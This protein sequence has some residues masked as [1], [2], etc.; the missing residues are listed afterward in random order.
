MNYAVE[1]EAT[2]KTAS[3][4]VACTEESLRY[5]KA[6]KAAL[7]EAAKQTAMAEARAALTLDLLRVPVKKTMPKPNLIE[8]PLQSTQIPPTRGREH[9]KSSGAAPPGEA[10]IYD[11]DQLQPG[12]RIAGRAILEDAN[13]TYF[14]PE[15]WTLEMDNFGNASLTRQTKNS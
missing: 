6:L 7:A 5:E 14:V 10:K 4:A 2:E 1:I 3:F 8:R 12:N 13:T 9:A 11:W 15:G